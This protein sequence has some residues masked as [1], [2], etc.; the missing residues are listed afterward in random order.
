MRVGRTA[1]REAR[2]GAFA[3]SRQDQNYGPLDEGRWP[4]ELLDARRL[5]T[6]HGWGPGGE[7]QRSLGGRLLG[8]S[9]AVNACMIVR[10]SPADYDEWGDGWSYADIRPHLDRAESELRTASLGTERPG[11]FHEAFLS[12][13][14]AVGFPLLSDPSQPV[15]VGPFPANVVDGRRWNAALAYLEPARDRPNLVIA[16]DTLVDR[17]VVD[18]NRATGVVDVTGRVVEARTIVLSAGA[19]FSPAILLR[20]G[21]GPE[22]DLRGLRIPVISDLPTG[23][24]LLDHCGTTVA[25]E[26]SS[27]LRPKRPRMFAA[28]GSSRRT[29]C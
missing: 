21:I 26:L 20:S 2:I 23:R 4:P 6:T 14:H 18:G 29:L 24:R 28:K 27:I 5:A 25:W 15:G 1:E 7:D 12:A 10:G 19:Y 8:G 3:F 11:A 13:A 17:V 9:S 22:A 16:A